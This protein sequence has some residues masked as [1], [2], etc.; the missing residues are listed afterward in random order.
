LARQDLVGAVLPGLPRIDERRLDTRVRQ[1]FQDRF[2]DELGAVV[3]AQVARRA[4]DT[5][6]AAEDVNDAGRANAACH[7]DGEAF[8]RRLDR[9][10]LEFVL[11]MDR[12][13][14]VETDRQFLMSAVSNL[15]QNALKYTRTG[16]CVSVRG[17]CTDNG[18]LV[19]E[20]RDECGGL[21]PGKVDE[22]FRP[23]ARGAAQSPGVGLGLSIAR[24]AAKAIHGEIRVRDLPGKGCIF[25][26]E[27]PAVLA[28]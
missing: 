26:V 21:P 5:D 8:A 9:R 24:R 10:N 20:V 28:R 1:P 4:V 19:I 27:L 6:E 18:R 23:F 15:V 2:R 11:E 16:G 13:L 12:A 25:I 7:V 3:R 14:E 22:L 17:H